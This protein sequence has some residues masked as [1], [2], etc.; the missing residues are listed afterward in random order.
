M[1]CSASEENCRREIAYD[2][3]LSMIELLKYNLE[4]KQLQLHRSSF[5]IINPC[6]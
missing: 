3:S 4:E 6:W 1:S 2:S 5:M